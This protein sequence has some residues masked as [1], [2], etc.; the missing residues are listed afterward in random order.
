[1]LRLIQGVSQ[2]WKDIINS[3][4]WKGNYII[5]FVD[6]LQTDTFC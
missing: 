3:I 1:M 6:S 4:D 5:V 2:K